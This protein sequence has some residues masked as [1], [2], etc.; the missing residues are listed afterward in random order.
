ME[1]DERARGRCDVRLVPLHRSL[2]RPVLLLGADREL[3]GMNVIFGLALVMGAGLTFATV[4]VALVQVVVVQSAL[5]Y[6]AKY[7]AQFRQVYLRHIAY[8]SVYPARG[9]ADVQ[10]SVPR[11]S[12]PS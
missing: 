8:Q 5:I 12:V 7:D 4:A 6:A 11:T 9:G 1:A 3:T 2:T 10:T